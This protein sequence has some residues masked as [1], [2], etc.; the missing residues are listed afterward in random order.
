MENM[1]GGQHVHHTGESSEYGKKG[2]NG[3]IEAPPV[4]GCVAQIK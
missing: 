2:H 4:S 3:A 1:A